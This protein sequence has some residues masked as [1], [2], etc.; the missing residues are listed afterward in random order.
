MKTGVPK[1]RSKLARSASPAA[2]K[3]SSIG[4]LLLNLRAVIMESRQQALRAVDVVQVRTC[5]LVGRHIVEF[6]QGGAARAVY[7]QSLLARLA[8]HLTAEF[9]RGFDAS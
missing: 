1:A 9:G 6:E 8:E 4:E 2:P 5:W 7:G 3:P